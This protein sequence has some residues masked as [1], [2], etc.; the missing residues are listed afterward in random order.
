MEAIDDGNFEA[1]V[2]CLPGGFKQRRLINLNYA[3]LQNIVR[4]RKGHKLAEWK[5]FIDQVRA[6]VEHPELIWPE[7]HTDDKSDTSGT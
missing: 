6:R 3:V 4:Q 1:A 2:Q 7:E 5:E